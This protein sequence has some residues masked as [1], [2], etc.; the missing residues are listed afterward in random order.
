MPG[1]NQDLK[2][3]DSK[4]SGCVS[5]QPWRRYSRIKQAGRGNN[6][7]SRR[8]C[9]PGL[10]WVPNRGQRAP[11]IYRDMGAPD[12]LLRC[13]SGV[14]AAYDVVYI[15]AI[16]QR[17][18]LLSQLRKLAA[19]G[20][21]IAVAGRATQDERSELSGISGISY[22]GE[23]EREH[24]GQLL[25]EGKAGLNYVPRR[26]PYI[27]QTSTKIIEYLVAGL[28]VISNSYPWIE[29]HSMQHGYDFIRLESFAPEE[30]EDNARKYVLDR[31]EAFTWS[32]ILEAA[33]FEAFIRRCV[34]GA[35]EE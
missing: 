3:G 19:R 8:G 1:R 10:P 2:A 12:E 11:W 35:G 5:C 22:I 29:H 20:L 15:G 30:I 33:D 24:V 27:Y 7:S 18:G 16:A 13:R 23:L 17:P 25:A 4:S 34:S 28:P 21:R 14:R 31:P 6:L 32:A 9:L 26:Y